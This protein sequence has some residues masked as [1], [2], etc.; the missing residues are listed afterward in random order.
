MVV[1]GAQRLEHQPV[2]VRAELLVGRRAGRRDRGPDAAGGVRASRHPRGEL[3]RPLTG[4]D[5]VPVTV[6]E[7]GDDGAAVG[8]EALA[9]GALR[10]L[11]ARTR[12]H[13]LAGVEDER[14]VGDRAQLGVVGD[15]RADVVDQHGLPAITTV[16]TSAA[17]AA[18]TSDSS[19]SRAR[20]S[21]G[22]GSPGR[23]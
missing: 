17:V 19:R 4:E 8:V 22:A 1:P 23:P 9:A 18:K 6:H 20:R 11:R 15:E 12:P 7:P 14:G 21:P 3:L 2:D 5:E 13:D 16:W 10:R